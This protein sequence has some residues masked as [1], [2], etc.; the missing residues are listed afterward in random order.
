MD[1]YARAW[2]ALPPACQAAFLAMGQGPLPGDVA[3]LPVILADG[4]LRAELL[5]AAW[6]DEQCARGHCSSSH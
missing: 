5:E 6:E 4:H 3:I 2:A 1:A